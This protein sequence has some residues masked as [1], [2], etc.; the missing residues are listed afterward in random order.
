M[1]GGVG[2]VGGLVEAGEVGLVVVGA[3]AVGPLGEDETI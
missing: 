2:G 3:M 1:P